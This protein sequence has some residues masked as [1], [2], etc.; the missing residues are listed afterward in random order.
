VN[1]RDS[2]AV[3]ILMKKLMISQLSLQRQA[4]TVLRKLPNQSLQSRTGIVANL[5]SLQALKNK[6]LSQIHQCSSHSQHWHLNN[7]KS[8]LKR[9]T[10]YSKVEVLTHSPSE[11]RQSLPQ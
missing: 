10:V 5:M 8:Q 2:G 11:L 7:L 4:T 1:K 6:K 3:A 9:K